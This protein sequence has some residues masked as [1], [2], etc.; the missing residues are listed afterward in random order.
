MD[1]VL[2]DHRPITA[3]VFLNNYCNNDCK[4]CAYKRWEFDDGA[5]SMSL[6]DFQ[7]YAARLRDLG[8]LG[9]ILSGGGEPTIAKDFDK[10]VKWLDDNGYHWGI[11]TNFN[12]YFVGK[13]DYLKVSLDAYDSDSYILGRGVDAYQKVRDNIIKFAENRDPKTRLGIQLLARSQEQVNRFYAANKDLPVDYISI[14]PVES[15]NGRYYIESD[16][17]YTKI[18]DLIKTLRETDD[19]V[20]LNYKWDMIGVRESS[21]IAQWSQIA[22]NEIGEVMYC[23]HKPYQIVG[24]IMDDNILEKKRNAATNMMMCDIPCRLTAPNHIVAKIIQPQI[25]AEFI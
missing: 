25:N 4:Y 11:N 5:R 6:H 15:T 10:I 20:V 23:C 2:G 8:V 12:R 1:R 17:D 16:V 21:C 22:V 18:I 7:K 9:I 19:R 13:P 14:R 3:D 24:H